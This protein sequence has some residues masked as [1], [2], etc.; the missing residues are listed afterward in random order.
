[1]DM[2]HWVTYIPKNPAMYLQFESN[3]LEQIKPNYLKINILKY[4]N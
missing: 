2:T 1:M 3:K 4:L